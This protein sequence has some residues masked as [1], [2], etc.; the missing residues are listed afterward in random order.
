MR[1]SVLISFGVISA[2]GYL[3]NSFSFAAD[4]IQGTADGTVAESQPELKEG[5]S[6]QGPTSATPAS[7][8]EE[9]K[10]L[11]ESA[12]AFGT[13]PTAIIGYYQVMYAH[14]TSTNNQRLDTVTATIRLPVTPNVGLQVNMPYTWAALGQTGGFTPNGTSDMT[15]RVGGRVYANDKMALFIGADGSFPTAS[16]PLLGTGKYTIGPGGAVAIPLPRLRSLFFVVVE[17]F[18]SIG[19]DPSRTTLHYT[20]FK[21]SINTIWGE[22]WWTEASMFLYWDWL[23]ERKTTMN[24]QGEVGHRLTKHWALFVDAGGGVLGRE[25]FLGLDWFVQAGVRWVFK[26]PL[27]PTLSSK[28]GTHADQ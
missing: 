12:A 14:S 4:R 2:I 27:L 17:D 23:H 25:A 3:I 16:E 15:F 5:E 11:S 28:W 26:T 1:M 21:P 19:G 6:L 9:R 10:R 18:N 20:Q 8:D 24:L 13:D 7:L 22:R